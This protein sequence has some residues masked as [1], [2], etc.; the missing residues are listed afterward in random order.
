[1]ERGSRQG[2]EAPKDLPHK[3]AVGLWGFKL[4]VTESLALG[5]IY[6]DEP[7]EDRQLVSSGD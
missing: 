4:S 5:I 2:S 1:M 3:K 6:V 7:E